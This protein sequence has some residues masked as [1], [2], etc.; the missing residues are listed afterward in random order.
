MPTADDNYITDATEVFD[1][2]MGGVSYVTDEEQFGEQEDWRLP[3]DVSGVR[4]DCDD[5]A[6]ACR[7]M[8]I[9]RG[10]EPRL[11]LCKV[12]GQGHLICI[13]GKVALDNRMRG[14]VKIETLVD[15]HAYE[16]VSVRGTQPGD[17]WH[18]IK[19]LEG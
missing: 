9:E 6:I 14:I 19:G 7:T 4:G 1:K 3:E 16:L 8:L 12:R 11:V 10:H 15:R 2:I 13:L 17:D 5:F 18:A